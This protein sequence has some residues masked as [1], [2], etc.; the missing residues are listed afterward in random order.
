MSTFLN[1]LLES[2]SSTDAACTYMLLVNLYNNR[3]PQPLQNA[4]PTVLFAPHVTQNLGELTSA[5][6]LILPVGLKLGFCRCWYPSATTAVF[7][8]R[9]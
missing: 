5:R 7:F 4:A 8:R 1:F 6:W 9:D 3:V 2:P